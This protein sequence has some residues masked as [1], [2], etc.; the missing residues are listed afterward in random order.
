MALSKLLDDSSHMGPWA[1]KSL[2]SDAAA[3]VA[4]LEKASF[5]SPFITSHTLV[6]R[7]P[8]HDPTS[9]ARYIIR[10]IMGGFRDGK[11]TRMY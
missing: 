1:R 9:S 3:F 6:F 5:Q 2:S 8:I 11:R 10:P 4:L 7:H